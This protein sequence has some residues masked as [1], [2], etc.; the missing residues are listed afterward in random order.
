MIHYAI[1][2]PIYQGSWFQMRVW[3]RADATQRVRECL[4]TQTGRT[5]LQQMLDLSAIHK[6]AAMHHERSFALR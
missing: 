3:Q 2:Y 6:I 4:Q 1:A 5:G